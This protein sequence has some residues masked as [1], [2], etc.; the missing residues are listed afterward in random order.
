M[1][2][3]VVSPRARRELTA[4]VRWIAGDNPAAASALRDAVA[5]AAEQL[6]RHPYSGR[7]RNELLPEPYRFLTLSGF[8]YVIVYNSERRPPL[9]VAVLHTS[10]DIAALLAEF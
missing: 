5:R 9:I 1:I 6:G 8:P 10:R 3:A 2:P 4:A 7:R